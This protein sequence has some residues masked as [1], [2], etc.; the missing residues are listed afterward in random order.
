MR[1]PLKIPPGLNGD[2]TT[3]AAAG[4]WA[5]CN[6]VRFDRDFPQVIGGWESVT[7][8]LLTGV[9][10]TVFQWT[11]SLPTLNIAF[12]THSALQVWLG[13]GLY[14]VTPTLAKP[15]FAL[16]TAGASVTNGSPT[17]T[18]VKTAH[19]LTTGDSVAVSGGIGVGRIVPAGVYVVTV[20]DANSF[21]ITAGANAQLS[22][23]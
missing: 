16:L 15:A 2:D 21:T 22:K 5:D 14:D 17:I 10:R 8:S 4:R 13:G 9:C 6:N 3:Y 19:G 11:D 18:I 23:T 1:V 20:A 12:G 7:A